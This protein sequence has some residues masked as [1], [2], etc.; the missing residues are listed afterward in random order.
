MQV[1]LILMLVRDFDS[2]NQLQALMPHMN[3][4]CK[5]FIAPVDALF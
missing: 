4:F 5:G 2:E 3:S 1:H